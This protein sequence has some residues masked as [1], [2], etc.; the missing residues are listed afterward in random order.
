MLRGYFGLTIDAVIHLTLLSK[1]LRLHVRWVSLGATLNIFAPCL[2]PADGV[3]L[4][5]NSS[6]DL[7]SCVISENRTGSHVLFIIHILHAW[8]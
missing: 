1:E 2:D 3:I 8:G 6:R 7:A 5:V 4:Y